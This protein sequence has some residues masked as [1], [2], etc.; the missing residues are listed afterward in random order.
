MKH[1]HLVTRQLLDEVTAQA[2]AV[3]RLRKNYNLHASEKEPCNRLLNAVEPGTYV[4]PHCHADPTRDETL[5]MV[6]GRMGVMIF[7]TAG[8]VVE[9]ALLEAGGETCAVSIP[10]GVMHATVSLE[11]GTIFFEAKAGPYCPLTP[12]EKAAW[13][14]AE[15]TPDAAVWVE[16]FRR[17]FPD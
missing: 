10:H 16:R 1:L 6:R 17:M 11:S 14:P 13:A 5:F 12:Q 8:Q 4:I 2:K 7:D 3:P 15:G 9:K